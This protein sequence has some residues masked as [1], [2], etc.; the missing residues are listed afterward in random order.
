M[1]FQYKKFKKREM[2]KGESSWEVLMP[3]LVRTQV[4]GGDQ[5]LGGAAPPGGEWWALHHTVCD[6]GPGVTLRPGQRVP[7]GWP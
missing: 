5:N 3:T 6:P 4:G 1:L 2:E 7:L